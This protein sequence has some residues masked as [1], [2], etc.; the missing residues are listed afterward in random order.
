VDI[1][2]SEVI[3]NTKDLLLLKSCLLSLSKIS[4]NKEY[5][6]D[7]AIILDQLINAL[8]YSDNGYVHGAIGNYYLFNKK[9]TYYIII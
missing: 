3:D 1:V 4:Q 8:E 7:I 9:V 5:N 2:C 6:N